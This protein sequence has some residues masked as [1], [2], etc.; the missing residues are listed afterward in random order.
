MPQK[1]KLKVKIT[2]SASDAPELEGRT[3]GQSL[4][5]LIPGPAVHPPLP[6]DD[7]PRCYSPPVGRLSAVCASVFQS[8]RNAL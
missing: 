1:R 6:L 7:P 4:T 8:A 3:M 2:V 5:V